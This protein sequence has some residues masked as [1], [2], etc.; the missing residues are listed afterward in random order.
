[1]IESTRE[2]VNFLI[3]H[4]ITP[5][6]YLLCYLVA[7]NDLPNAYTYVE[8]GLPFKVSEVQDLIQRG[9][10][11]SSPSDKETG[12]DSFT[13][14]DENKAIFVII[15]TDPGVQFWE[16][17]PPF[18]WLNGRKV[19]LKA[20]SREDFE[21]RYNKKVNKNLVRH[22]RIM[23]AL[24]YAK[25]HNQVN[26]GIEKWF[27]AEMWVEIDRELNRFMLASHGE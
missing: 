27:G 15:N 3:E 8:K 12:V 16:A 6:Q 5:N 17:Y 26:M 2:Y 4:K 23:R 20:T 10:L 24:T 22:R 19:P 21:S 14:S 1:M 25:S 18:M 11:I 9:F 7:S 13:M